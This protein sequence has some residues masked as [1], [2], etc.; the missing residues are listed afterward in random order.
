M[1]QETTESKE[2]L[3][4]ISGIEINSFLSYIF[5]MLE[6]LN[7]LAIGDLNFL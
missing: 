1:I 5:P 3:L 6:L 2:H 4:M 7:L